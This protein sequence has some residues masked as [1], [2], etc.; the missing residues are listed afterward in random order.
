MSA[1][2]VL[3]DTLALLLARLL[4]GPVREVYA[5]LWRYGLLQIPEPAK[6]EI[7]IAD[8]AA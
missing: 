5:L 3:A 4:V 6:L 7:E 2:D 1:D 8:A